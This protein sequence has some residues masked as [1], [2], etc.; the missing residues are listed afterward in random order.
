M[1]KLSAAGL[2]LCALGLGGPVLA[3]DVVP[4]SG[5]GPSIYAPPPVPAAPVFTWTGFYLG[6]NLGYGLGHSKVEASDGLGDTFTSSEN[7]NGIVGGAQAGFN[8]QIGAFLLGLETDFQATSQSHKLTWGGIETERDSLPWFGTTRARFGAA[9]GHWLFYG[10]AGVAYG[11]GRVEFT[12]VV[13]ATAVTQRVGWAAG[14]GAEWA[15][16][17]GLTVR[18]EYL[19]LDTGTVDALSI[20]SVVVSTRFSDE[21]VRFGVNYLFS[22]GPVAAPVVASY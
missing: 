3:A 5:P 18:A 10:T 20:G 21:I 17:N 9:F 11:E 16:L 8:W 19:H 7:L 13:T 2:A 1:K 6:G 15:V 22:F 4:G 12:G 14:L